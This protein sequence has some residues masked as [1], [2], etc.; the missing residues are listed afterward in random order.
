MNQEK[1][2][3][4]ISF[5]RA[6]ISFSKKALTWYLIITQVDCFSCKDTHK[7]PVVY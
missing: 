6:F 4:E 3:K 5:Y 2:K 7:F 1:K